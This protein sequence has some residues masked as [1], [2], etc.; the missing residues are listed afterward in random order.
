[1]PYDDNDNWYDDEPEIDYAARP[2]LAPPGST[3]DEGA[4]G[5]DDGSGGGLSQWPDGTPWAPTPSGHLEPGG[6][7]YG[8]PSPTSYG[9]DTREMPMPGPAPST[10]G[11]APTYGG[12]GG[13]GGG[14]DYGGGGGFNVQSLLSPYPGS[15]NA[16][17]ADASVRAAIGRLPPLERFQAPGLP[18]IQPWQSPSWEQFQGQDPGFE[19]RRKTGEQALMNNKAAQGLSRTGGS[20]KEL[21]NYNSDFAGRSYGDYWGREM[22]GYKTNVGNQYAGW[23]RDFQGRQ[24]EYEPKVLQYTTEAGVGERAGNNAFDQAWKQYLADVD[25]WRDQRDSTFDKLAWQS[26]FGLDA[27]TR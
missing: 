9:D 26:D 8:Y 13:G 21:L 3:W 1:M 6:G 5:W 10:P 27:A 25:I 14:G 20:L 18:Q 22:E 2:D 17:D 24:A 4:G 15:F 12:G 23:D 7:Y 16:P 19:G 11:P